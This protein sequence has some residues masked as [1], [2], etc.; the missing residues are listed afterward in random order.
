MIT[1]TITLKSTAHQ[2]ILAFDSEASI[3]SAE[4]KI[5]EDGLMSMTDDYGQTASWAA[6]DQVSA[7]RQDIEQHW[8]YR[9]AISVFKLVAEKDFNLRL[10]QNPDLKYLL[11]G[12]KSDFGVR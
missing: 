3:R 2:I 1:L 6:N 11:D 12:F 8:R 10:Q 9:N 7:S 5:V 4:H